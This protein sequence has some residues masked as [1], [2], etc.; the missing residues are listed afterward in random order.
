MEQFDWFPGGVIVWHANTCDLQSLIYSQ[1]SR[2]FQGC[3]T[4]L[5]VTG[6]K[7][8]KLLFCH[9]IIHSYV[10]LGITVNLHQV[11][12]HSTHSRAKWKALCSRWC[13]SVA[14]TEKWQQISWKWFREQMNHKMWSFHP[15]KTGFVF[16][17][18]KSRNALCWKFP[19]SSAFPGRPLE[20]K[21]EEEEEEGGDFVTLSR[22]FCCGW[23]CTDTVGLDGFNS[24]WMGKSRTN[25]SYFYLF[26]E[27]GKPCCPHSCHTD[28][29]KITHI[30]INKPL[31][32]KPRAGI[33]PESSE[34]WRHS[35]CSVCSGS[36]WSY[37]ATSW[38]HV[39]SDVC[40]VIGQRGYFEEFTTAATAAPTWRT[41]QIRSLAL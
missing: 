23:P 33:K 29:K 40:C 39:F 4:H 38:W 18:W 2:Q 11:K 24:A 1:V 32:P 7:H 20:V 9:E 25:R 15:R 8:L 13:F 19:S 14:R 22:W 35:N 16:R 17:I 37:W 6:E 31:T 5:N 36:S 30:L 41:W 34:Y 10:E 26:T 12:L 3:R 28:R 21:A 27:A